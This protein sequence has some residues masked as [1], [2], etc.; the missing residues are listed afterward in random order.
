MNNTKNKMD[1]AKF[2]QLIFAGFKWLSILGFLV[3]IIGL[4][5][6]IFGSYS[7]WINSTNSTGTI[8]G[9]NTIYMSNRSM[10]NSSSN[11]FGTRLPII[12]FTDNSGE[13]VNFE[14]K[15]GHSSD[16]K[17]TVVP[18]IFS[19]TNPKDAIIDLGKFHNWLSTYI[20]LFVM[21]ASSLGVR[22]FSRK[23][24]LDVK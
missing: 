10:S 22:N 4:V 18:I 14:G 3:S 20:W 9:Y 19:N 1:T 15:Y 12:E 23:P 7:L 16:Q 2:A 5:L 17:G 8:I 24:N 21:V 6:S 13:N 11:S